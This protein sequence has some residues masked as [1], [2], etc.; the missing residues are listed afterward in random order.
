[1]DVKNA[2]NNYE[3]LWVGSPHWHMIVFDGNFDI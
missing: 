3:N 2:T 1:M